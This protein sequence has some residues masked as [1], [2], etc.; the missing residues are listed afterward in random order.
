[1]LTFALLGRAY[2]EVM[3]GVKD[4][5]VGL[6][7]NGSEPSKG[8]EVIKDAHKLLNENLHDAFI[9]NIEPNTA[10]VP[11]P[12]DVV[13]CDGFTGNMIL[14]TGE[15]AAI[16]TI[17]M[18]KAA[19]AQ[20]W[21]D[22]LVLGPYRRRLQTLKGRLGYESFG[23]A[24]LL[25]VCGVAIVGHG[26]STAAAVVNAVRVAEQTVKAGLPDRLAGALRK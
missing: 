20:N 22:K 9:G 25:G 19:L 18:V 8:T 26:S 6:I 4:P 16:L 5:K 11:G 3:R 24:P 23:G 14:K 1:L 15:G 13:V 2:A 21:W 7:S 10:F 17:E 12:A